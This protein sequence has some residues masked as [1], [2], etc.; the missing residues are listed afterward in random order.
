MSQVFF[1][2]IHHV[3]FLTVECYSGKTQK[4]IISGTASCPVTTVFENDKKWQY[5]LGKKK[6]KMKKSGKLLTKNEQNE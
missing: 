2:L 5:F 3:H 1:Q 6:K 4:R